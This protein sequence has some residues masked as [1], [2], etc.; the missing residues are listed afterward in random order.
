[1]AGRWSLPVSIRAGGGGGRRV[2]QIHT[3][4]TGASEYT[5]HK[6]QN[7]LLRR[8]Y[9]K[10]TVQNKHFTPYILCI[11][12]CFTAEYEWEM[13]ILTVSAGAWLS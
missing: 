7:K 4:H 5:K 8:M 2:R 3:T 6:I 9:R 11:A 12:I 13:A 10:Y 1:M